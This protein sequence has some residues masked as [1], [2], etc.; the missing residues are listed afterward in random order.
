[1]ENFNGIDYFILVIFGL[2]MF[3]GFTRGFLKEA[4]SLASWV[5]AAIVASTYASPLAAMFTGA[6]TQ[7]AQSAFGSS[8][9]GATAVQGLSVLSLVISF[10][11]L[12]LGVL[13]IGSMIGY[14]F[15]TVATGSGFGLL[16]RLMGVV[17]GGL[18]GYVV[19]VVIIFVL[20]LT[21]LGMQQAW[22]QSQLVQALQPS[23]Q[24]FGNLASPQIQSLEMK[25]MGIIQNVRAQMPSTGSLFSK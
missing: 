13:L 12:F 20:Q 16:N 6:S 2:S 17:F 23:V 7:A 4:I 11:V 19:A 18:R 1:M 14:M 15:S 21:P 22:A 8:A 10:I 25:T 3:V 9:M 24:W 5:I